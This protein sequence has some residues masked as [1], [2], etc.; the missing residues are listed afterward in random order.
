MTRASTGHGVEP[1][2]RR[3]STIRAAAAAPVPHV[4]ARGSMMMDLP[5]FI[6]LFAVRLFPVL[7]I[8]WAL[9]V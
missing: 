8:A 7:L 4:L 5:E 2:R 9:C 6:A 1:V 3:Q